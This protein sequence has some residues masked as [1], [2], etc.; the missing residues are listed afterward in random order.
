MNEKQDGADHA[1]YRL[2]PIVQ[3]DSGLSECVSFGYSLP[4]FPAIFL[5]Y[6]CMLS[7]GLTMFG[8][9]KP[10]NSFVG[11]TCVFQNHLQHIW[12]ECGMFDLHVSEHTVNR[13]ACG[14]VSYMCGSSLA[15][16]SIPTQEKMHV[17]QRF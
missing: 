6:T 4:N 2:S 13:T 8:I 7:I 12:F 16:W 15:T 17:E 11:N 10:V 3:T 5:V 1:L 14:P 9:K